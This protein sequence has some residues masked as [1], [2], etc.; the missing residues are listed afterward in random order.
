MTTQEPISGPSPSL[1]IMSTANSSHL[2]P[3]PTAPSTPFG[4]RILTV[5]YPVEYIMWQP[6]SNVRVKFRET[7]SVKE[8]P[9]HRSY[10]EDERK[11]MWGAQ[12]E[13]VLNAMRNKREW[14]ADGRSL[15]LCKEESEMLE[16]E[17]K[18]IHPAT[19]LRL[20]RYRQKR[21]VRKL[22]ASKKAEDEQ[23]KFNDS[24]FS[25]PAAMVNRRVMGNIKNCSLD[26]PAR[27]KGSTAAKVMSP[28]KDSNDRAAD[29]TKVV[30]SSIIDFPSLRDPASSVQCADSS[31]G[32]KASFQDLVGGP[33]GRIKV[34]P[35]RKGPKNSKFMVHRRATLFRL[36]TR[37]ARE[38]MEATSYDLVCQT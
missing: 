32:N 2:T 21:I 6:K 31:P 17:G 15:E 33:E 5:S 23:T 18:L 30:A 1:T 3:E 9:P 22:R 27:Y 25:C 16:L 36:P 11:N 26:S 19:Y 28:L 13:I 35:V 29:G 24:H 38:E 12:K 37:T 10:Q 4:S 8:I 14:F 20:Q 34:V 7:V